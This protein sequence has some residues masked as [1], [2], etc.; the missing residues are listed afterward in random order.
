MSRQ[1]H[2]LHIQ[3]A[4]DVEAGQGFHW[5]NRIITPGFRGR[6][7]S[8]AALYRRGW[9]RAGSGCGR[10]QIVVDIQ[11]VTGQIKTQRGFLEAGQPQTATEL[12]AIYQQFH[13]TQHEA[14]RAA[15]DG[16]AQGHLAQGIGLGHFRKL[17]TQCMHQRTGVKLRDIDVTGQLQIAV[18]LA[19]GQLTGSP[20]VSQRQAQLLQLGGLRGQIDDTVTLQP[21]AHCTTVERITA[22][23]Q[24][25]IK[26]IQLITLGVQIKTGDGVKVDPHPHGRLSGGQQAQKGDI[27][28][29]IFQQGAGA[30]VDLFHQYPL[31]ILPVHIID[32]RV[33]DAHTLHGHVQL[34]VLL[35]FL[36]RHCTT[37]F[38]RCAGVSGFTLRILRPDGGPVGNAVLVYFQIQIDAVENHVAHAQLT[39]QQRQHLHA[40]PHVAHLGQRLLGML[41]R[42]DAHILELDTQPG[43]QRPADI[44]TQ[45]EFNVGLLPGSLLDLLLVVVRIEHAGKEEQYRQTQ[46]DQSKYHQADNSG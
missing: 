42:C 10:W 46:H 28:G 3:T 17:L 12:G 18:Q 2:L 23:I 15:I 5:Q 22:G 8:T 33:G 34:P 30:Q 21:H 44:T 43:K 39:A 6:L 36:F 7:G 40:Q 45:G 29:L 38:G 20:Q 13:I 27:E 31:I 1:L 32:P 35:R 25:Q 41:D 16:A 19:G 14:V 9:R 11:A 26:T 37:R 24:L 4:D